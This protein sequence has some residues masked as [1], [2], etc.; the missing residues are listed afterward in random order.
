[1]AFS[2][3]PRR[4]ETETPL[5]QTAAVLAG[6]ITTCYAYPRNACLLLS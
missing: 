1:M 5:S 3:D 4:D 2:D 6:K